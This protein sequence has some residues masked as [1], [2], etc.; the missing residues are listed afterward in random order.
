MLFDARGR[1]SRRRGCA[2]SPQGRSDPRQQQQQPAACF[3][4]QQHQHQHRRALQLGGGDVRRQAPASGGAQPALPRANGRPIAAVGNLSFLKVLNLGDNRFSGEIPASL[5][6]LQTLN[7]SYNAFSGE[8][9]ANLSSCASLTGLFLRFNQLR[10]RVPSN[11]GTRLQI[12]SLANNSFTGTIPA[13]LAN[14]V[15]AQLPIPLV[16]PAGGHH[17]S[18]PRQHPRP[19]IPRPRIQQAFRPA[20]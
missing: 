11:L 1:G 10:G 4:E 20:S 7:L 5:G 12:L 3:V 16:Y 8:L 19:P 18:R 17:S 9:P 15:I 14:L 13:S 2:A 6:R